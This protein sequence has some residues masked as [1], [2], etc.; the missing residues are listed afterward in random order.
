MGCYRYLWGGFTSAQAVGS[1]KDGGA[2]FTPEACGQQ[3]I[4]AYYATHF[5]TVEINATFYRLP[6]ENMVENWREKAPDNFIFAVKGS[7]FITQMKKLNVTK[8]S[9]SIFFKRIKPLREHL[10]PILWQL[11]PTLHKDVLRLERFLDMV[12]TTFRHAVEFRHPSWMDDEV[13]DL[14]RAHN[15]A[16][17]SVSSL[18][19]PMEFAVTTDFVYIRFHG[20]QGGFA[21]DYTAD[22]LEPWAEHCQAALRQDKNVYAYFNN[23]ANA[24]APENAKALTEMTRTELVGA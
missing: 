14:L 19:M 12:P 16:H 11:P 23:D 2:P 3:S 21:H 22:E 1:T 20:L 13:F 6:T 24:R 10:G 8:K 9:I 15:A 17:V 4:F 7:R 5:P 18:R